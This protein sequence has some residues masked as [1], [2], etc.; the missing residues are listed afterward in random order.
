LVCVIGYGVL[1]HFQQYFNYIVH[2]AISFM[3]GGHLS[4]Q[5]KPLTCRYIYYCILKW[6]KCMSLF[7]LSK[8]VLLKHISYTNV[9]PRHWNS[10]KSNYLTITS[11]TALVWFEADR[12]KTW[13]SKSYIEFQCLGCTFV[14]EICFNKTILLK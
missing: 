12:N 4:T 11:T 3:G 10:I 8:I 6:G 13:L 5:R 9:Q 1:R 2:V 7:Y 14:Y